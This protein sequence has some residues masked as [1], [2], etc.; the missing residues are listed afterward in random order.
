M[1]ARTDENGFSGMFMRGR[2]FRIVSAAV[3]LSGAIICF[4]FFL[5]YHV[6]TYA[7]CM[8]LCILGVLISSV[9]LFLKPARSRSWILASAIG[10]I[11]VS[12]LLATLMPWGISSRNMDSY[13]K[14]MLYLSEKHFST[15]LF[16]K[17]LPDDASDYKM[18]F[19]P[20]TFGRNASLYVEFYCGS[21]TINNYTDS[22]SN[23][24]LISPLELEEAKAEDLDGDIKEEL[25]DSLGL[26]ISK[27]S[28][29]RLKF[30][31]PKDIDD[32]RNAKVY[33]VTCEI[34]N[35]APRTEAVMIDSTC[36]WVCFSKL[37]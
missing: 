3:A 16:P 30:A 26:D 17:S 34:N 1:G 10:L 28:K 18:K 31:F 22:I 14:N 24:A 6:T 36:G 25:A 11:V 15:Q 20:N 4:F 32:H 29:L 5:R 8:A 27:V 12:V 2:I 7:I 33:I 19:C 35:E 21:D 37:F 9:S 23:D 13:E